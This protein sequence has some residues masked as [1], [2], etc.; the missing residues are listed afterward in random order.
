MWLEKK[1]SGDKRKRVKNLV[2]KSD[3]SR[4]AR[5]RDWERNNRIR[6][7]RKKKKKNRKFKNQSWKWRKIEFKE[8]N[9]QIKG[10][11][12]LNRFVDF[13]NGSHREVKL[14][15]VFWRVRD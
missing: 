11:E 7:A 15:R 1:I 5:N 10:R 12:I 14:T 9:F 4:G 6:M 2:L 13:D 8:G 3:R